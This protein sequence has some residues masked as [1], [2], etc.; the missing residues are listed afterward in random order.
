MKKVLDGL[1]KVENFIMIVTFVVMVCASFAQV[2]NRNFI[3]LSIGWFDE[4]AIYCMMYMVLIGTEMGLRDGTQIAVTAVVDKL[5]G[6]PKKVI[7][8][9]N[10]TMFCFI[11]ALILLVFGTFLEG[12]ATAVLLVPVLWPIASSFGIDVIHFGM[13]VCI[14]NVI[15]TMTPP[16]A[17]NIFSAA[18]VSKLKMGVIA[19]GE[20]PFFIGYVLVFFAVVFF[21][22][23]STFLL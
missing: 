11:I 6:I 20:I 10:P 14:S 21:P 22:A 13:I 23:V 18:S 19:K 8:I 9:L 7:E 12:I 4:L 16:V 3:K 2:V 5:K 15:G 1:T 17:V